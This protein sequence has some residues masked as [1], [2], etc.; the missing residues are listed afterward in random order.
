MMTMM[1]IVIGDDM[2]EAVEAEAIAATIKVPN[3]VLPPRNL[4][5]TEIEITNHQETI[6]MVNENVIK[7][8][9][10]ANTIS[11][12]KST[13][14]KVISGTSAGQ[15]LSYFRFIADRKSTLLY[16]L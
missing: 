10:Q 12:P 5:I 9:A 3:T 4:L 2:V 15:Q 14:V 8:Q 16:L 7:A 1:T 11:L 6:A 13:D